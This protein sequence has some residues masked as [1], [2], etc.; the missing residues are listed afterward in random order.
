MARDKIRVLLV[1]DSKLYRA[2]LRK[3]LEADGDIAVVAEAGNGREALDLNRD[4]EP[5]F[6]LMD[7]VMPVMDGITAVGAMLADRPVPILV[8]TAADGRGR[9]FTAF[10]AL[11]A[12]ALDVVMKPRS[13]DPHG[14]EALAEELPAKIRSLHRIR[15]LPREARRPRPTPARDGECP[16]FVI[17]AS[18]GGPQALTTLLRRL[19][20]DFP[21]AVAVVQHISHGF[22]EGLVR[23]LGR[24]CKM[25]IKVAEDRDRL[26]PGRV[27]FAPTQRHLELKGRSLFLSDAPPRNGCRPSVDVLFESAAIALAKPVGIVLTG[28]GSDGLEGARRLNRSGGRTLVQ[29]PASCAATGMPKAVIDGGEATEVLDVEEIASELIRLAY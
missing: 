10:E 9:D 4:L 26:E 13:A 1:D 6:V 19:P 8:L 28:M 29:V 5:D 22:L 7:V 2:H 21:G 18:T 15:V 20:G 23:W 14:L 12:G 17:G 11:D 24:D 3:L 16:V 25:K 27:Y